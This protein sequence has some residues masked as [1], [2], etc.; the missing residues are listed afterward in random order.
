MKM[1]NPILGPF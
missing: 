1:Y